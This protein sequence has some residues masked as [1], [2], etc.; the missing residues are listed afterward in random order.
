MINKLWKWFVEAIKETLNLSWTLVGLIIA[1]L[2]LTGSAQQVT[3][4]A[5]VITLAVWL[6]TIGFRKG[7]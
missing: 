3:G 5:T 6:L 2:T 1:T 4:V 7:E